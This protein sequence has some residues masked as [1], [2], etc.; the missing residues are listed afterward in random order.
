MASTSK[1]RGPKKPPPIP[2]RNLQIVDLAAGCKLVLKIEPP[3]GGPLKM[4]DKARWYIRDGQGV[5]ISVS[6]QIAH[7]LTVASIHSKL[8][9]GAGTGRRVRTMDGMGTVIDENKSRYRVQLDDRPS[10]FLGKTFDRWFDK[11]DCVFDD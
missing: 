11:A 6:D 4:P 10:S 8:E 9:E 1:I 2:Q 7:T 5:W 3:S